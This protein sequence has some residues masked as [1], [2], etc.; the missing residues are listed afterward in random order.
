MG[1]NELACRHLGFDLL[2]NAQVA[3]I[4][5]VFASTFDARCLEAALRILSGNADYAFCLL[6]TCLLLRF[7]LRWGF[8]D[9]LTARS[10]L[11]FG[12]DLR[13]D[14]PPFAVTSRLAGSLIL[15]LH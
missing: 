14:E 4:L 2:P 11:Q 13:L 10:W 15:G 9:L 3:H 7:R 12:R 8:D 1:I 5:E 6:R